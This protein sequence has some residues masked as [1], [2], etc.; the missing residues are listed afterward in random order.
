MK[1]IYNDKDFSRKQ[2]GHQQDRVIKM[3]MNNLV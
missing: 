3:L 2:K 1:N